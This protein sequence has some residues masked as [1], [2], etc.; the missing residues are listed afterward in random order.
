MNEPPDNFAS[1]DFPNYGTTLGNCT[2]EKYLPVIYSFIFL[3]GFPENSVAISMYSSKMWLWKSSSNIMLILAGTEPLCL[4]SLP[5]LIPNYACCKSW[6]FGDFVCQFICFGFHFNLNSILFLTCVNI[7]HYSAVNHLMNCFPIHKTRSAVEANAVVWLI[8][9]PTVIP[10][11]SLITSTTRTNSTACLNLTMVFND[12]TTIKW[13]NLMLTT[14][15]CFPLVIVTLCYTT[16]IYT[17]TGPRTHSL[18]ANHL[19]LLVFHVCFLPF[20]ILRI[21]QIES[22]LLSI[23][24]SVKSQIRE[25]HIVSIPLITLK[26]FGTNLFLYVVVNNNFQEAVCSV[27]RCKASGDLEQ[28]RK[29]IYSN[30]P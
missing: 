24:C 8:F 16:I 17:L 15:F 25:A 20:H 28:A 22:C 27:V 30:S 9:L 7:F 10:I 29:I 19:L 11:S 21:I 14:T 12:L 4:I 6:I 5:F 2:D 23:S 18:E 26:T 13:C 1:S 3:A